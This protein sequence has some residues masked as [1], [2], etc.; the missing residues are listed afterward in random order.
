MNNRSATRLDP[1]HPVHMHD[2][3]RTRVPGR[4]ALDD[5]RYRNEA[6][7]MARD[8]SCPDFDDTWTLPVVGR[9]K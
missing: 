4:T 5:R 3:G 6:R 1:L 7:A 8:W 9:R 2:V